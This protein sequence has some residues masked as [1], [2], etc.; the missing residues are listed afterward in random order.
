MAKGAPISARYSRQQRHHYET[1]LTPFCSGRYRLD[2]GDDGV[3][4]WPVLTFWFSKNSIVIEDPLFPGRYAISPN[5]STLLRFLDR[6]LSEGCPFTSVLE[7]RE[8]GLLS[9]NALCSCL[10]RLVR[11]GIL[12]VS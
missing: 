8:A 12:M 4:F 11:R 5:E 3:I 6:R 9:P 10:K 2:F 7:A 1:L